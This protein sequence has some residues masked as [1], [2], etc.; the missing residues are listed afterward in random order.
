M[1]L[2][3]FATPALLEGLPAALAQALAQVE[4]GPFLSW[5]KIAIL[6]AIFVVWIGLLP[7]MDRDTSANRMPRETVNAIQWAAFVLALLCIFLPHFLGALLGVG[8]GSPSETKVVTMR[9]NGGTAGE[10][11]FA[12]VGKGVVF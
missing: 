2:A 1:H 10:A 7:W 3:N 4:V 5:W 12:F 9:W 11:P 8:Q 6:A